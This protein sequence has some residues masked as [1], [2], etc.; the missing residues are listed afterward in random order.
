M[1]TATV[2]TMSAKYTRNGRSDKLTSCRLEAATI[3]PAQ[4]HDIHHTCIWIGH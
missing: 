4:A 2:P 1:T 3:C